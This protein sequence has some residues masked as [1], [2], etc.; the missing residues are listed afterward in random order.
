[1]NWPQ[2]YLGVALTALATIVL[3]LALTRIFSVVFF[4]HFAFLAISI[5]LFGL[6]AGGLF[7]YALRGRSERLFWKLGALAVVNSACVVL[8]LS[9]ILS[10]KGDLGTATLA[11]VYLMSA[12]PFFLAGTVIST[13]IAET[14]ERIERVYFFDLLG[15]AAGCLLLVPL[16]DFIGGPNTVIG[17]AILFAASSA[18]WFTLGS[19]WRGRVVAVAVSLVLVTLI[20]VNA[21]QSLIDVRYAKGEELTEELFVKWNSFSRIALTTD[22]K[23]GRSVIQVDAQAVSGIA[24]IDPG[25]LTDEGRR[26]LLQ[27]GAGLP[28]LLRPGAKTLII[29][30]GGGWDIVRALAS[31]SRDVTGVELNPIIANTIMRD[32][33][34]ALSDRLYF[35]PEVRIAVRDGRSFIRSCNEHYQVLQIPLADARTSSAAGA[36]ALAENNL[37]TTEA[38]SDYLS[39]LTRDG[40]MAF[41]YWSGDPPLESLRLVALAMAALRQHGETQPWKHVIIVREAAEQA[42]RAGERDT[43]LIGR[44]P[45]TDSDTRIV[46]ALADGTD[47]AVIYLPGDTPP[48]P[49]AA[50]LRID[51]ASAHLGEYPYDIRPV[52]DNRPFFF[53][54]TQSRD[55]WAFLR[56]GAESHSSHGGHGAPLLFRLVG[57]SMLATGVVLLLPPLLL[58]DRLAHRKGVARFL[59]YFVFVGAGYIL[60]QV[61][62]IQEFILFLGHPTYA[63]TVIIFSMLVSSGAGSYFSRRVIGTSDRSLMG[64]LA[65]VALFIAL[66]AVLISPLTASGIGWRLWIKI[67]AAVALIAPAGFMMGMAFPAGMSRLNARHRPSVRWAWALNASASVMGAVWS[68]LLAIHLGLR[69]TLLIGA[70]LYLCAL[71]SIG[72][73]KHR[74]AAPR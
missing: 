42:G 11:L 1:M 20:V 73:R 29:G 25:R 37:Y 39:R 34:A 60:I 8:T 43:V 19:S 23:T 66:L 38:F 36:L 31:G 40:L 58:A 10:R 71:V 64:V 57:I 32:R 74:F 70:V 2:V 50:L 35:R 14:I 18:I 59:W 22:E 4:Y 17:A 65:I 45:F 47:L 69:E 13:A 49:F 28:Y 62:L 16:L 54:T 26:Q 24:N 56:N 15:A 63:L 7:S 52:D 6:G 21:K 72:E 51:D 5:A 46:Q 33:Y 44:A 68:V 41:T 61:A 3:E 55:V 9:F 12:V 53:Y 30:P 48:N 27:H 67:P